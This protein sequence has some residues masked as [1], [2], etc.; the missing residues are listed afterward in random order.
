ML[1]P[2]VPASAPSQAMEAR[3]TLASQ[4]GG[5]DGGG[6]GT[7]RGGVVVVGRH[8]RA[9]GRLMSLALAAAAVF[10]GVWEAPPLELG[11][12]GER[13]AQER[14]AAVYG[15]AGTLRAAR[16]AG[17]PAAEAA[18]AGGAAGGGGAARIAAA[19]AEALRGLELAAE[20]SA[21]RAGG[22]G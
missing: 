3:R 20:R 2:L 5:G 22:G 14:T 7:A 13:G 18:A 15:G 17:P 10:D 8:R 1:S 6:G 19:A 4:H 16:P 21:A 9:L 11:V 12:E